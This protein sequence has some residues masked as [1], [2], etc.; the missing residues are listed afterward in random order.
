MIQPLADRAEPKPMR[1]PWRMG[2]NVG[3]GDE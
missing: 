2:E 3:M 1:N